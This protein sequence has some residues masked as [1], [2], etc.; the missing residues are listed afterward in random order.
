MALTTA[1]LRGNVQSFI[2]GFLNGLTLPAYLVIGAF[3]G[4]IQGVRDWREDGLYL[5]HKRLRGQEQP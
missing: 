1:R 2:G 3:L 4:A 5:K